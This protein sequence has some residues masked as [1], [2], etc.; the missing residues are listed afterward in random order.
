MEIVVSAL[1][2]DGWGM[3]GVTANLELSYRAPTLANRFYVLRAEI[4]ESKVQQNTDTKRWVKGVLEEVGTGKVFVEA[5]G[6]FVVPR[7]I[8]LTPFEEGF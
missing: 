8:K 7:G 1:R 4:D 6:L 5:K 2:A 3:L